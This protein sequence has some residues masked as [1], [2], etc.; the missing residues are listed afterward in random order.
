MSNRLL[1]S[2]GGEIACPAHAPYAGSDSFVLGRWRPM[3]TSERVD[4]HAEV[5]RAPRCET[6]RAIEERHAEGR[7]AERKDDECVLCT[8]GVA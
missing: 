5:G 6:C 7:H 8:G 4:F 3:R 2:E 1:M